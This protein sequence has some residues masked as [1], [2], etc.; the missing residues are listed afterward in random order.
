MNRNFEDARY[1]LRRAGETAKA[2]VAEE[3]EPLQERI[4]DLTGRGEDETP[5]GTLESLQERVE[6]LEEKAEGEAR[7]ALTSAKGRLEK[8]RDSR[9]SE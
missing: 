7:R 6:E 1:Y 3:L 4:Q 2:G 9:Q 5:D 8:V